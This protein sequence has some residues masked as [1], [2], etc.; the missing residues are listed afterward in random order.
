MKSTFLQFCQT[1][2]PEKVIELG[3][4]TLE[5]LKPHDV[6][7]AIHF[8]PVNPADLNYIEGNYGRPSHPPAIPGHEAAGVVIE[9]G[10][11]VSSLDVG[12]KVIPLLGAGCWC[13]HL[14]A[15]EQFFAKLPT[16][17]DLLQASMLRV[18]P[19]TAW[20]LLKD[21]QTL[22]PGDWVAQNAA[23]SGVGRSLIQIAKA[24]GLRSINFVRRPELIPELQALG[25]D[26][27]V[28][29]NDEG[30]AEAKAALGKD[31]LHLAG[32]AVGGDSALRLMD[33]LAPGG[34]HVTYGAMS[35]R[36]L[37]VPNKFLIFKNLELRGLWV[38]RWYE[39]ASATELYETLSPLAEMLVQQTLTLAV[40][41]TFAPSEHPTAL[42][43][44]KA[45][46]RAGKVIFRFEA[47]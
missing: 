26:I 38:T 44:A 2:D 16:E 24:K 8:A 43:R 28:L 35:K 25:A 31:P 42:A 3:S 37:K 29:D 1:G 15:E 46:G 5:P 47:H 39:K 4:R 27:V 40:D 17:V 22:Q 19:V 7:V 6:R 32:N 12:D 18:N 30:L 9:R 34:T 23:N 21:Y 36:S 45:D 14:T 10:S 41:T 11:E 20:R 13:Q 33:L